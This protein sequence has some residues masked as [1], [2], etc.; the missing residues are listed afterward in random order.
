MT[1]L[2]L[3]DKVF[4][5]PITS[6]KAF[7]FDEQVARVFDDMINRSVP[8]YELLVRLVSLYAE[9]LVTENSHVYEL[10]CATGIVAGAIAGQVD[11]RN[12]MIHAVDNSEAMI[13]KCRQTFSDYEIN[14][15][16]EDIESVAINEASLVVL[17]LTLQFIK[18][19]NRR[20]LIEKIYQGLKKGGA[21][22]LTEKV[23]FDDPATQEA[24][25]G[26]YLAFKKGQG[27]SDLEISQKR[28]ALE[29]VLIPDSMMQHRKR[30]SDCGFESIH[31]CF[32][33]LNFVSY[34][35]I[36]A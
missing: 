9:L 29:N 22:V 6:V 19:E 1:D 15:L 30:L 36:K 14:W 16:C 3:K 2:T 25:S 21:L 33:C 5:R 31:E 4:S 12:V 35:A 26:L 27:Y 24:M 18:P 10:G 32:R 23:V 34:L 28:T 20:L 7:E 11:K 13:K 8:G 17:N